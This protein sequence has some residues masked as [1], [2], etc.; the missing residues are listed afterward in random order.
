[1][2]PKIVKAIERTGDACAC[3]D[4][5]MACMSESDSYV[6]MYVSILDGAK[7]VN[8]GLGDAIS[9]YS[10]TF[11]SG[12]SFRI[13]PA[14]DPLVD[15]DGFCASTKD[16]RRRAN[17]A[18][19]IAQL[20]FEREVANWAGDALSM[21]ADPDSEF[22]KDLAVAFLQTVAR[23][24]GRTAVDAAEVS[25]IADRPGEHGLCARTRFAM[26]DLAESLRR[27]RVCRRT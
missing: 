19:A 4:T 20:G 6:E 8:E 22:Q 23:H 18:E 2:L 5:I 17:A 9:Q 24:S 15:Y 26:L 7:A 21:V 3:V 13:L 27:Q 25:R 16:K 12:P 11:L 14:P 10:H 1:M